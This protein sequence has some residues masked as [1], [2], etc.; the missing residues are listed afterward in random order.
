SPVSDL[1]INTNSP[2]NSD[3]LIDGVALY[4]LTD[5]GK[6]PKALQIKYS[7]ENWTDLTDD[8][9]NEELDYVDSVKTGGY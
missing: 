4:D 8:Q 2:L 9:L 3:F 7:V 5:M 1:Y 6:L